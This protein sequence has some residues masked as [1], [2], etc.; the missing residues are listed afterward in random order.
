M[1]FRKIPLIVDAEQW[2]PGKFVEG[3]EEGE[4]FSDG[5]QYEAKCKTLEGTFGVSPGDWIV[6]GVKGERWPIKPDIFE[7]SYEPYKE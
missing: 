4:Y 1:K 2:F 3:V 6:T 7:K 5:D